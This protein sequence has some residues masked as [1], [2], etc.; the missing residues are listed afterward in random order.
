MILGGILMG[1]WGGFRSRI[2]TAMFALIIMGISFLVFWI[3]PRSAFLLAVGLIFVF[4]AMNSIANASFFA[5]LQ[6]TIPAEIQGRVFTLTMSL[7]MSMTPL[8]LALAG[9]IADLLGVRI[10]YLVAGV[11]MTVIGVGSFFV[12]ALMQIEEERTRHPETLP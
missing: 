11:V 4:G 7:I 6:A 5:I 12:S 3:T 1:V 10:W 9:P 8:G 2:K